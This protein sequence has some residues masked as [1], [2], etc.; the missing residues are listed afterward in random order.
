[1]LVPLLQAANTF[2]EWASSFEGL[3]PIIENPT[4]H[5]D[6]NYRHVPVRVLYELRRLIAQLDTI[7]AQIKQPVQVIY[8]DQDPVVAA[9]SQ[10][11]L[12]EKLG[13]TTK[14]LATI[15]AHNHGILMENTGGIWQLIDV[16]LNEVKSPSAK[17]GGCSGIA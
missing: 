2:I 4:E 13:S 3:K 10:Q 6:I 16:F 17:P 7:L 15:S 9:N 5:P 14:K 11:I 8:A 12:F 1:M